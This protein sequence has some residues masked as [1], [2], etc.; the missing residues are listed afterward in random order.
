MI[1]GTTQVDRLHQT[2]LCGININ[3]SF[4]SQMRNQVIKFIRSQW[5]VPCRYQNCTI[6]HIQREIARMETEWPTTSL[7][8]HSLTHQLIHHL[9]RIKFRA[10]EKITIIA[11]SP[12][13]LSCD[14]L[15][16]IDLLPHQTCNAFQW[17]ITQV[18][19]MRKC[20]G[21]DIVKHTVGIMKRILHDRTNHRTEL[22]FN[23]NYISLIRLKAF[24]VNR[25]FFSQTISLN[26]VM[27]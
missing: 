2:S 17:S 22:L 20:P 8:M 5:L 24:T 18:K 7:Y 16:L 1:S 23:W 15:R 14:K 26:P 12:N 21:R 4:R 11:F 25:H 19:R 13:Y 27:F 10:R 9:W 3:T 6:P